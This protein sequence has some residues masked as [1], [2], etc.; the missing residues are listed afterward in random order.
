MLTIHF[1]CY[2]PNKTT[3]LLSVNFYHREGGKKQ[4]TDLGNQSSLSD[5]RGRCGGGSSP[6]TSYL[7]AS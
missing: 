2:F 6:L 7:L 3:V 5:L 4:T 1:K